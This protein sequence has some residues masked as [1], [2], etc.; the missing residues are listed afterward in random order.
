LPRNSS[1]TALRIRELDGR[2]LTDEFLGK[3]S[4]AVTYVGSESP[5][6]CAIP[7]RCMIHLDRRLTWGETKESATAE[8]EEL[9]DAKTTIR[10]PVYDKKSY[11]GTAF[12]QA[13]YF[14]TW[15]IPADHWLVRAGVETYSLLSGGPPRLDKWTFSTNGVAICGKHRIPCIGF[16]P[17][18]EI[19]AHAPNEAIPIDHL[20]KASAFYTLF[21]YVLSLDKN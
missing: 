21:P 18:N 16:G 17:G 13:K 9:S 8:L 11:V 2:L 6:L 12:G 20:E 14:P 15:R 7:D 10:I 3:G 19:Y 1:E 5:S 4:V